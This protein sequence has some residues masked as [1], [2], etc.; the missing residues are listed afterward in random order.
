MGLVIGC[1]VITILA[2]WRIKETRGTD[3]AELSQAA[4][5]QADQTGS[6]R[7]ASRA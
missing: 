1:G 6:G 3:L 7:A 4:R 2:I 5:E